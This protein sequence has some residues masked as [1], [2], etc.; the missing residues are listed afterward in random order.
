MTNRCITIKDLKPLLVEAGLPGAV[1]LD[2]ARTADWVE[3]APD[4]A[5]PERDNYAEGVA[6]LAADLVA[7]HARGI[8]PLEVERLARDGEL[9]DFALWLYAHPGWDAWWHRTIR[10]EVTRVVVDS[11]LATDTVVAES[12]RDITRRWVESGIPPE[13]AEQFLGLNI[14]I[15]EALQIRTRSTAPR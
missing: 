12:P 10:F 2:Y 15:D 9:P 6:A 13:E 8:T 3:V 5:D 1:A 7:C 11:E 4:E 14:N